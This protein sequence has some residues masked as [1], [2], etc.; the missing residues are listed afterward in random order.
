[1]VLWESS[2]LCLLSLPVA[3]H[4]V[5]KVTFFSPLGF[6]V[7]MNMQTA[8]SAMDICDGF[9]RQNGGS[10]YVLKPEFLCDIQSSFDPERPIS[11]YKAKTLLVQ[12]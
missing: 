1:M 6:S 7:A 12:V 5:P 4:P 10:G 3:S 8:G 9:F 2:C 11:P